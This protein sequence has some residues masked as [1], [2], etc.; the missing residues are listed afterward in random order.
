[1]SRDK[2]KAGISTDP[3]SLSQARPAPFAS[4][5][6]KAVWVMRWIA[7]GSAIINRVIPIA[8]RSTIA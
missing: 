3:E 6:D 2:N 4:S 5:Q 8:M 1:M 7:S